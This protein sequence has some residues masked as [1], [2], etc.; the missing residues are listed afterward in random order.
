MLSSVLLLA[1]CGLA[2]AS[3][4][5]ARPKPQEGC[6]KLLPNRYIPPHPPNAIQ[7]STL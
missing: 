7:H 3:P 6:T 1:L 4:V 5:G 2:T